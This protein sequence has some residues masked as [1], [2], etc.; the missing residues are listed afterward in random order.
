MS[1]LNTLK[2]AAAALFVCA[3]TAHAQ[4]TLNFIHVDHLNTPRLIADSTGTTVWRNDNSEPFGDS[5]ADENPS[6][7]GAFP[8]DLGFS[9]QVRD[10]ETSVF[11]NYLRDC[12][13]P[14]T[15]RY[16]QPDPIGNVLFRTMAAEKL[17]AVPATEIDLQGLLFSLQPK[18]NDLYSYVGGN[19]IGKSD[20]LGLISRPLEIPSGSNSGSQSSGSSGAQVCQFMELCAYFAERTIGAEKICI[21]Q[22]TRGFK[23]YRVPA[24]MACPSRQAFF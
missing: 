22:C 18:L 11:Y 1:S 12:Y 23:E 6:G 5:V 4:S 14:A 20:P 2:L 15:E 10:R 17:H 21:Y 9:G 16:C 3:T 24:L 13:D 19:P 7:L 8:F